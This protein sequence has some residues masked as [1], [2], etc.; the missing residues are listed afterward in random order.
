MRKKDSAKGNASLDDEAFCVVGPVRIEAT[1]GGG[2]E[3]GLVERTSQ[4]H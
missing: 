4:K 1:K 3:R 2:K